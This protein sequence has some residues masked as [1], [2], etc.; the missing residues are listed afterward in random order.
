MG[1]INKI[2]NF[3]V[4]LI[5]CLLLISPARANDIR[6]FQIEGIS[7][8][9]S[10]LKFVDKNTILSSRKYTY[11]DSEFYSL[12]I[13]NKFKEYP[14]MQ[15]HLKSNDNNYKIYGLSG[16]LTF[17]KASVYYPESEK[18]CKEKKKSIEIEI[19]RL[20]NNA[21]KYSEDGVGQGDYDPKAIRQETYFLLNDGQV[22]LQCVTWGKTAK[23]KHNIMDNLRISILTNEFDNWMTK[24]A[25]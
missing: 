15:F 11:K 12:D 14:V 5:L 18:L 13:W 22:W 3:L 19:A 17:G 16:A 8:G 23:K 10:L 2:K 9:D 21:K 25:Y 20:F 6:D 7:I 24:K 1:L 4:F